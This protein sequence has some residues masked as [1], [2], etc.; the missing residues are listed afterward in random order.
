MITREGV[1]SVPRDAA[2]WKPKQDHGSV[3]AL[4]GPFDAG[5]RVMGEVLKDYGF[6]PFNA[7]EVVLGRR[8]ALHIPRNT[9]SNAEV[10][11]IF[12]RVEGPDIVGK[13]IAGK[14]RAHTDLQ[15][16]G[17]DVVIE[18]VENSADLTYIQEHLGATV[19]GV[20]AATSP[21]VSEEAKDPSLELAD[22]VVQTTGGKRE[23][24]RVLYE[25]LNSLEEHKT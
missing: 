21:A 23:S 17:R 19:I 11:D 6:V 9:R 14:V 2:Q 12:R 5:K 15:K 24:A 13:I 16:G 8:D 4:V 18:G 22:V 1:L 7:Q 25:G 3:I 10:I 20:E